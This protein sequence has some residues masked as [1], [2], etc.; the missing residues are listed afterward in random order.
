MVSF[1]FIWYQCRRRNQGSEKELMIGAGRDG[2]PPA[3]ALSLNL[4][5]PPRR[6]FFRVTVLLAFDAESELVDEPPLFLPDAARLAIPDGPA[7]LRSLRTKGPISAGDPYR[8]IRARGQD[9]GP[10]PPD[11]AVPSARHARAGLRG[12]L[13]GPEMS[14]RTRENA[15]ST[16]ARSIPRC[17]ASTTPASMFGSAT[18]STVS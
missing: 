10:A 2:E 12:V 7:R 1:G 5:A 8:E 15:V 14:R 13:R 9:A 18:P 11:R 6:G 4:R 17:R 16:T 3:S